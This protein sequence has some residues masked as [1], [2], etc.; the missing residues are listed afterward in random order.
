MTGVT[1]REFARWTLQA[2][3]WQDVC[4][5]HRQ[6]AEAAVQ[7]LDQ[8]EP[9]TWGTESTMA[10][11]LRGAREDQLAVAERWRRDEERAQWGG[12]FL[13]E[14]AAARGWVIS[15][16]DG[17]AF[18]TPSGEYNLS[19]SDDD[20]YTLAAVDWDTAVYEL[21]VEEERAGMDGR[22]TAAPPPPLSWVAAAPQT[23]RVLPPGG[24]A[25]W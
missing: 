3:S 14:R 18:R 13:R 1:K 16:A 15:T 22:A 9:G 21:L 8:R 19:V 20:V 24:G 25:G 17:Q 6:R 12:A 2:R 4:A 11:A 5:E 10:R 7:E 23:T